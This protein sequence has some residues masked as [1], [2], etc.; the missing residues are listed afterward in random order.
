MKVKILLNKVHDWHHLI[1]DNYEVWYKGDVLS[2]LKQHKNLIEKL[3][4][5]SD[6]ALLLSKLHGCFAVVIKIN[7]S[8][9]FA[10]DRIKSESLLYCILDQVLYID[11]FGA[12]LEQLLLEKNKKQLDEIGLLTLACAGYASGNRT[13][14]AF[15]SQLRAGEFACYSADKQLTVDSYYRYAPRPDKGKSLVFYQNRLAEVLLEIIDELIAYADG[16]LIAI[17]LSAGY[18]SRLILSLLKHQGYQ[19]ILCYTYGK[20]NGF[21]AKTADRLAKFLN[22]PWHFIAFTISNQKRMYSSAKHNEYMRYADS[23]ASVPFVQD[24]YAIEMLKKNNIIDAH[25]IVV[26]GNSGDFISGA[27]IPAKCFSS[28]QVINKA[29]NTDILTQEL[30]AKHYSLW[31]VLLTAKNRQIIEQELL[32]EIAMAGM[33]LSSSED[34]IAAFEY[35]EYINRQTKYVVSGQ[36]IYEFLGLDWRLPLWHDK[37]MDFWRDVPFEYKVNQILYKQTIHRYNWSNVWHTIKVNRKSIRPQWLRPIR[38]VSKIMHAPFGKSVWH[39]SEKKY[40][41]YL[42]DNNA[43]YAIVDYSKV[44]RDRRGHRNSISWITENYLKSKQMDLSG[45]QY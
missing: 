12:K 1:Q 32:S 23:L 29:L 2:Q 5:Q 9:F 41:E 18:D 20:R 7:Q 39:N 16:R 31:Q 22:V 14:Y 27:H 24:Y 26:N 10:V 15:I 17:P 13:C 45:L 25:T 30:I 34:I 38:Y 28:F 3:K 6:F 40:F 37:L 36:K 42:M 19:N 11:S 21:E 44:C 33:S 8:I 4:Q 43:K 35:S